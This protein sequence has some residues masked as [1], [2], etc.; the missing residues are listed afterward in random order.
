MPID[1]LEMEKI[2]LVRHLF[3]IIFS[4]VVA[5]N[6]IF[7]AYVTQILQQRTEKCIF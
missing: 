1:I 7:S 2:N 5:Q 6:S 3:Q 4:A